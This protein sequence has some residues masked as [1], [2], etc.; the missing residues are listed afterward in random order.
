M[1]KK[2]LIILS[3]FLL[4]GLGYIWLQNSKVESPSGVPAPQTNAPPAGQAEPKTAAP[5]DQ[6]AGP[7]KPVHDQM[8]LPEEA[9]QT[10]DSQSNGQEFNET[11]KR[12]EKKSIKITPGVTF[13]PGK[14]VSIKM[15]GGEESIQIRRDKTYRPDELKVEW[16]KKF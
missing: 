14:G 5:K 10:Y 13:Q 9:K 7:G 1:N 12:E 15:P 4:I 3:L 16:E 8:E 2:W 11:M 6:K